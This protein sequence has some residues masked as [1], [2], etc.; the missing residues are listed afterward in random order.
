MPE[1]VTI[2]KREY[3]RLKKMEKVDRDLLMQLA[4]SLHDLKM[5]KIKKVA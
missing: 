3:Q 2:P 5:G 4:Q 1:N